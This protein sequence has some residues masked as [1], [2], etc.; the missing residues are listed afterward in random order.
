MENCEIRFD[1]AASAA[2]QAFL[3]QRLRESGQKDPDIQLLLID[4][5]LA[6]RLVS[7]RSAEDAEGIPVLE[8]VVLDEQRREGPESIFREYLGEVVRMAFPG[9]E[10]GEAKEAVSYLFRETEE[11]F[12]EINQVFRECGTE[13]LEEL[14]MEFTVLSLDGESAEVSYAILLESYNRLI[15][16]GLSG[17]LQK[18][19]NTLERKR[20]AYRDRRGA[21][22]RICHM[23]VFGG[24]YL[25]RKQVE[26]A[27]RFS[28]RDKRRIDF[29][30]NPKD[31]QRA[32][33]VG[34]Q[35]LSKGQ[36]AEGERAP[37]SIGT[38]DG[39]Y[40]IRCGQLIVRDRAYYPKSSKDGSYLVTYLPEEAITRF[41]VSEGAGE[42]NAGIRTLKK[43]WEDRLSKVW[44]KEFP[45]AVIGFSMDSLGVPRIHIRKYDFME[46]KLGE[47]EVSLKLAVPGELF[48]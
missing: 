42:Y 25:V 18:I 22:F 32:A 3:V 31:C 45:M 39:N 23:G 6:L 13:D 30:Q 43:E 29:V 47:R 36:V 11:R 1:D 28:S 15:R 24:F 27:F 41:A 14:D 4:D 19:L 34:A 7:V 2:I 9:R 35:M 10:I 46:G 48:E 21:H 33:A 12:S 38:E 20:I 16:E 44:P 5:A 40:A 37:Y 8:S 26:D 17:R